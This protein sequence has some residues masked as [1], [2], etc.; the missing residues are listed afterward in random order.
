MVCLCIADSWPALIKWNYNAGT[1]GNKLEDEI[2]GRFIKLQN[3]GLL[4]VTCSSLHR[5]PT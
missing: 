3:A 4:S 1:A 2:H 5:Y